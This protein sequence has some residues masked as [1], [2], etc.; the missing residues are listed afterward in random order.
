M[1]VWPEFWKAP[2]TAP[3]AARSRSASAQTIMGSLPPS[4]SRTGVSVSDAAAITRL[5]VRAEP[6]KQILSTP[7]RTRASPVPPPPVTTCTS[8]G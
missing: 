1:Q 8:S 2:H 5:P 4:S 3:A 6:V 7:E